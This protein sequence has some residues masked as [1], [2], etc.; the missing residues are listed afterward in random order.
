MKENYHFIDFLR[1]FAVLLVLL[2]HSIQYTVN[3]FDSVFLF[4][5]IYSFHM[6]LFF[7]MSGY[8]SAKADWQH[9]LSKRF[10]TLLIPFFAWA[11]FY[12]FFYN[13]QHFEK[14][15]HFLVDFWRNVFLSP[16]NG[17]L[18][19][20]WVLFLCNVF[21][22]C[23]FNAHNKFLY[24]TLI[25]VTLNLIYLLLPRSHVMGLGLL[26]WFFPFYFV[27]LFVAQKQLMVTLSQPKLLVMST[28]LFAC[29][30]IFFKRNGVIN[31]TGKTWILYLLNNFFTAFL[32]I[33]AV[34]G[35][36]LKRKYF[37]SQVTIIQWMSQQSLGIYA[38]QFI[39]FKLVTV[40]FPPLTF[41]FSWV[42]AVF[43][44]TTLLSCLLVY[45]ISLNNFLKYLLLGK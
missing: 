17:A 28:L 22:F 42:L 44:T 24:A 9:F 13:I 11:C 20:L 12:S 19:F 23:V 6:P 38:V 5:L 16:D 36:F 39:F 4:R 30:L 31:Q 21:H 26:R 27:G 2:G 32:G 41:E 10:K 18:W 7:F 8:L 43:V 25:F 29:G 34:M 45:L 3:D 1:C 33:V 40:Y 35:I 14:F 37:N 15:P